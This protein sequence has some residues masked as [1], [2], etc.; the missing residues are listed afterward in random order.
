MIAGS[1]LA[2]ALSDR[3]RIEKELGQGGMATVYLA[4]DLKHHRKVAIKVLEERS[5]HAGDARFEREIRVAAQLS[6]PHILSLH[7]SGEAA[8]H[9]YYVMPYVA[10]ETLRDRLDREGSL[11]VD[12]ALRL[13]AEVAEALD[14]AHRAGII[15]R[16]IKPENI[17]LHE[18]HAVVA[19][20]GIASAVAAAETQHLTQTGAVM[21]TPAYLSPEQVNGRELDGRSDL[22]SLGCV[23]FE[24]LTGGLPF[25]GSAMAMMAQRVMQ[26]A[27][28][29]RVK[30]PEIPEGLAQVVQRM[31]A[32]EPARR[33]TSG[34][35]C[36]MA[37]RQPLAAGTATP[38][39]PAIVVLPFANL[40][41]DPENEYFSDGLT[42]EIITD[43]ASV[44]AL[45]VI[46]RTSAMLLK[47]TT[48]DVRT[49]G[50]ELGV[51]YVLEGGVRKAGTNL[52]ITATLIDAGTDDQLWSEKFSGTMDDIFEVQERVAR[53]IVGALNVKLSVEE[54]R[55]LGDRPIANARAYEL[56]LQARQAIQR[57]Q[58][59]RGH[60]LLDQAIAIEGEVPALR[61]LRAYAWYAMVRM[62]EHRDEPLAKVE[63][64][65]RALIAIAP[66]APYGFAL[67]GY[68]AYERGDLAGAVRAFRAAEQRDPN[69]AN[70]LFELGITLQAASRPDESEATGNRLT[71][72]DPLSPFAH[73]MRGANTWFVGRGAEGVAHIRTAIEIDPAS[74]IS[75]W[76]LG[77]NHA[78][79]GQLPE[80]A[81]EAHW[82]QER[83]P[84]LPYTTQLRALVA[85]LQGRCEEAREW[86]L[87][88]DWAALDAH[89]T[90]H[91]CE[92]FIMAGDTTRG[93]Q[94]F[95]RAVENGFYP[96][97]Y[98]ATHCPFLAPVRGTVE[99]DRILAR[100]AERVAAFDA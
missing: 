31:M 99:F 76:A 84:Q 88:V 50:R 44:K 22:Y 87:T 25:S 85:A 97:A 24:C 6:H 33:Y 16:D 100:A 53:D 90:F 46:S 39:R 41:P 63:T 95:E 32:T 94:L 23:L 17:M 54:D 47:G 69:D 19:D 89:H 29:V 77:Y 68:A 3:Y 10:G 27:P 35:A 65:A 40:S 37:L 74:V 75:H 60:A 4:E 82:M 26:E 64:E 1:P 66:D 98:F 73:L 14:C 78:L 48:K 21:G 13:A 72:R 30:R 15:H 52:R 36:V 51:R 58:L 70:V 62:G 59:E 8:G 71:E 96:H 38:T 80:A 79:A 28:S 18:G 92:S 83:A 61:A 9:R 49:I 2:A 55:R 81:A 11:A 56:Y 12:E 91:L 34:Q 20:F 7:D 86:L 57:Y 5:V 45:S 93:L 42:E 43:L 67:Q